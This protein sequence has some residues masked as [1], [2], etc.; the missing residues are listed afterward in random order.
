M[1]DL[2]V[3]TGPGVTLEPDVEDPTKVWVTVPV[4]FTI[5]LPTRWPHLD[6]IVSVQPKPTRSLAHAWVMMA[7]EEGDVVEPTPD[8]RA[9]ALRPHLVACPALPWLSTGTGHLN[10]GQRK[11]A[12]PDV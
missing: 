7:Q 2:T 4:P 8:H 3:S 10:A 9:Q 6:D 11:G 12:P 5:T 1:G